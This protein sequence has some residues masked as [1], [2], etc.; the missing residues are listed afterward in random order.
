MHNTFH[1]IDDL[2]FDMYLWFAT[3]K[4]F[5]SRNNIYYS[6]GRS[7][8]FF[9]AVGGDSS[10]SF[11]S[12]GDNFF[13]KRTGTIA[14]VQ[15]ENG[16]AHCDEY[17]T[18]ESLSRG[19][20]MTT[21]SGDVMIQGYQYDPMFANPSANIFSLSDKSPLIDSGVVIDG[22]NTDFKNNA[23]DIGAFE[24]EV[25]VNRVQNKKKDIS[26]LQIVSDANSGQLIIK[27]GSEDECKD[28][29]IY[30]VLGDVVFNH[31]AS[32]RRE[33]IVES[34]EFSSGVYYISCLVNGER[35]EQK[36]IKR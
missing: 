10:Y 23:P 2:G 5:Y 29:I 7:C 12:Q 22:L 36:L 21:G 8:L 25:I 6:E 26:N 28:L 30:S 1:S 24:H 15:P 13:D 17:K 18:V 4:K 16:V 33:L 34:S 9:D 31:L 20:A 14:I 35:V 27:V 11:D 32:F 3:W 19:L